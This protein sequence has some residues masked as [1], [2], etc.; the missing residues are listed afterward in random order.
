MKE[1]PESQAPT[2]VLNETRDNL[3]ALLPDCTTTLSHQRED[4]EGFQLEGF[5]ATH[6]YG[7]VRE[8]W[9]IDRVPMR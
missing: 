8:A 4:N 9:F 2:G 6:E 3:P 1:N 7:E 5:K